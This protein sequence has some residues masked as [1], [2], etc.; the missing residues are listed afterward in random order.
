[1]KLRR[2]SKNKRQSKIL[3]FEMEGNQDGQGSGSGF[4]EGEDGEGSSED[5]ESP[6]EE[7]SGVGM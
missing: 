2:E 1:M 7:E 3:K 5:A 6:L 4:D